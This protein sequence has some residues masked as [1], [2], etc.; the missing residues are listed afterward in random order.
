MQGSGTPSVLITVAITASEK[1]ANTS[2]IGENRC[3]GTAHFGKERKMQDEMND[4]QQPYESNPD[5]IVRVCRCKDCWRYTENGCCIDV[6]AVA[7]FGPDDYCS[8]GERKNA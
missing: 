8:Y 2:Q 3:G 5:D 7:L 1:I 6:D 4:L